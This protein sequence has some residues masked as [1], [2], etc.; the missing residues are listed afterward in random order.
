VKNIEENFKISITTSQN[1]AFR[2]PK[3]II[4]KTNSTSEKDDE[5]RKTNC[6]LGNSA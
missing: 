5:E 3:K 2:V 6:S 4:L 1:R